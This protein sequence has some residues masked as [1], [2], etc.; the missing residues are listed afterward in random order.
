MK[1]YSKVNISNLSDWEKAFNQKDNDQHWKDQRSANSLA[2][3]FTEPSIDHSKGIKQLRNIL[4]KI[5]YKHVE[6]IDAEIEHESRFDQFRG[7]G[8]MQDLFVQASVNGELIPICIEAKVDEA[9]GE[10][11]VANYAQAQETKEQNPQSK[12]VER[13]NNLLNRFYGSS[14]IEQDTSQFEFNNIRYQLLHY[15]AGSMAEATNK[16][17]LM[18]IFVFQTEQYDD[19]KAKKNKR[20]YQ[21]F[22]QS[23]GFERQDKIKLENCDIYCNKDIEGVSVWSA[24]IE[25]TDL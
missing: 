11:I 6:F 18:P 24:Y 20:D 16:V 5:G 10:T 13:I 21:D 15:L 14:Y 2:R 23:L 9:F 3:Y 25:I 19:N 4:S 1:I 22:M 7:H 17:V 8:R 12:K